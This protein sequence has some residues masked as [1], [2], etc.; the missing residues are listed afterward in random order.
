[1]RCEGCNK[2]RSEL[3]EGLCILC[4]KGP[5]GKLTE[6]KESESVQQSKGK[7]V[8]TFHEGDFH[9]KYRS[10]TKVT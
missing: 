10:V 1:M 4:R 5:G 2:D 8:K 7:E 3:V 9:R 6:I